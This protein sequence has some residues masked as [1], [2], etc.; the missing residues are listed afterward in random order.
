[1]FV[2]GIDD[3]NKRK[4]TAVTVGQGTKVHP[5]L[6]PKPGNG[7][8]PYLSPVLTFRISGPHSGGY[9]EFYLLGHNA[10]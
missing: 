2:T 1:L 10:V 3:E 6:T 8:N 7:Y 4:C 9:E 5:L